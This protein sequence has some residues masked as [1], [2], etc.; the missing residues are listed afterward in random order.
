MAKYL[1]QGIA[2]KIGRLAGLP[3]EEREVVAYGLD[4]LL[5]G[6]LVLALMLSIG[7][8]LGFF[9][10]TLVIILSWTS[11]RIFAGGAHCTALWRCTIVNCLSLIAALLITSNAVS[12]FPAAFWIGACTIW[13]L[14]A[15][16][17][18]APNNSERPVIEPERRRI[19]RNRALVLVIIIVF[20][21]IYFAFIAAQPYSST[22][23]AG[24]T[25]LAA[26]GLMISPIGF[27]IV[28]RLDQMLKILGRSL[29]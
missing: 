8:S 17:L 15:T 13:A 19:L 27:K 5:S 28:S 18:W 6:M 20:I 14:T 21:L 3:P 11:M 25:G 26:G 10:E 16:W 2:D 1:G 7:M 23:A 29:K 24:A 22:A 12:L 4:Y 9:R